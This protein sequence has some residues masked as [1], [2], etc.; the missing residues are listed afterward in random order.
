MSARKKKDKTPGEM[1]SE[2]GCNRVRGREIEK[3]KKTESQTERQTDRQTNRQT[4]RQT[5]RQDRRST[6]I[7]TV[8]RKGIKQPTTDN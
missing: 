8:K 7:I 1:N 5:D 3:E 2:I 4:D 6:K